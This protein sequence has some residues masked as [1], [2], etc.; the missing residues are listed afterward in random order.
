[1][2]F[3]GVAFVVAVFVVVFVEV[4]VV[5]VIVEKTMTSMNLHRPAIDY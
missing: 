2:R 3:V 1:M 5:I 4:V